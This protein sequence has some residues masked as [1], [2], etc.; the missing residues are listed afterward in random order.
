MGKLYLWGLLLAAISFTA[1]LPAADTHNHIK[2]EQH[3]DD[4]GH[5]HAEPEH[6][7]NNDDGHDHANEAEAEEPPVHLTAEQ[8][9][10]IGV[11][12]AVA[13]AETLDDTLRLN[14]EFQLDLDQ[15]A[16]IM[17][18]MP[19]FVTEICVREG[20][21]VQRGQV[22]AKLTSHKL[23]EYFTDYNSALE[24]E[25][26]AA[27]EYRMAE[28][29]KE[30]NSIAEKEFLRYK[31]EY[32]DAAIARNRA[33]VLL[34]SL[35]ID[36]THNDHLHDDGAAAAGAAVC[37]EYEIR[38]P[39]D[40]TVIAKNITLGE[41]FAEDNTQ[42][43]FTIS[44]LKNLWLDLRADSAQLRQLKPGMNVPAVAAGSRIR[45]EGKI[46]HVSSVIEESSRTGLVRVLIDNQAGD[47]RSGEFAVGAIRLT[48]NAK[49]VVVPREAVQLIAGETVVFVPQGD[50]YA[51]RVV[52]TGRTA[53]GRTQLLFGLEP[54]ER[55]VT[56]GAFEL[57]S[58]LLT[59]GMDA[60]AGHGH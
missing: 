18:R 2:A 58:V 21:T 8:Q 24:S 40:G 7:D 33:E 56:S 29:L 44:N 52:G 19:G 60:H 14:G 30:T 46:I 49:G 48:E 53:D 26:L 28:K 23:G 11:Q 20:E 45:H 35:L 13:R 47:L 5:D 57:K 34:K 42:V 43:V 50:G 55:Y 6:A 32:A 17:P 38:A 12:L 54:G 51:P 15:T 31:R 3:T 39:F 59:S 1:E 41:N 22:L 25:K 37:T 16:R 36:P 4:D 27:S 10:L 9:R